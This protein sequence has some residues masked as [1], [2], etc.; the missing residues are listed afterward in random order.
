MVVFRQM[1]NGK[2]VVF[3]NRRKKGVPRRSEKQ[4]RVRMQWGNLGAIYT[5]FHETLKRGFEGIGN[6]M[7]DY[8]AFMQSN[9]GLCKVYIPKKMHLNGGCVLAPYQI[10]RGKLPS[11]DYNLNGD[12]VLVTDVALGGLVITADTTVAEF[13]AAVMACN[14][15]YEEGDQLTFFYGKQTVD[16]VTGTPR[17]RINGFKVVL[18]TENVMKLWDVVSELGFKTVDGHLGMSQAAEECA[19]AWIHSREAM[20]GGEIKVSTQ[21]LWVDSSVLESYQNDRAFQA[22]ADSYGGVNTAAVYLNPRNTESGTGVTDAGSGSDNDEGT[23]TDSGS[24]EG[25]SEGSDGGSEGSDGCSEGSEGGSEGNPENGD[26]SEGGSGGVPDGGD[27][28][29]GDSEGGTDGG[30]DGE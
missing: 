7:S 20:S 1:K 24:S 29:E 14:D 9:I 25:G 8:N 2:T 30:T 12:N 23:G 4:M 11:I 15:Y 16:A 6:R 17:A 28:P 18:D 13:S 26:G 3:E 22:S 27:D 5:Q 21:Y 19:A 10:T